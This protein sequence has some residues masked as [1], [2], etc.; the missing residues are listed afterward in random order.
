MFSFSSHADQPGTQARLFVGQQSISPGQVNDVI[1]TQGLNAFSNIGIYGI[2][3]THRIA[4]ILNFGIR[5]EGKYIKVKEV[6]TTSANPQNPYYSSIQQSQAEVVLRVDVVNTPNF[7]LDTFGGVG[8][9]ATTMDIRT[10]VGEGNYQR[11]LTSIVENAGVSLG[12]GGG[13]VFFMLEAGMEWNKVNG[14]T[15]TGF[16]SSAVNEIDLSGT[17]VIAGLIFNG[18]PSF[19]KVGSK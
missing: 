9:A 5:G 3:V 15:R 19:I 18:L 7:K 16:T 17:Y 2:E 4:P 8:A 14:P 12:V 10:A 11:P 1:K 13:N 6:A